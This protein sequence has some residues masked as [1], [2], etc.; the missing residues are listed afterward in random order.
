MTPTN[1]SRTPKSV[2]RVT[3]PLGTNADVSVIGRFPAGERDSRCQIKLL[4]PHR[5]RAPRLS[6]MPVVH[7]VRHAQPDF[8]GN[9]DSLTSLGYAQARWL[10][11]HYAALG[12]EFDRL[13]AGSLVRQVETARTL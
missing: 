8:H 6:C 13:Y 4:S 5:Q 10:G 11:E 7:L 1:G 2:V 12:L 9:Y 3:I